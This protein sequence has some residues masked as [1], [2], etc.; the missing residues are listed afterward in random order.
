[1]DCVKK[2]NKQESRLVG[3]SGNQKT[4]INRRNS[5]EMVKVITKNETEV[6]GLNVND[7]RR[8]LLSRLCVHID[9]FM[10]VR[11]FFG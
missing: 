2:T 3:K 5:C 11:G 1:M 8:F 4:F 10:S 9:F 7:E 6:H